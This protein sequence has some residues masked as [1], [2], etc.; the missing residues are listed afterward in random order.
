MTRPQD[1]L[2]G[3]GRHSTYIETKTVTAATVN[4]NMNRIKLTFDTRSEDSR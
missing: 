2:G 3:V 1:E 4:M